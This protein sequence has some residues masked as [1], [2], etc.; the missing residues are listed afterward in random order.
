MSL[1]KHF[2]MKIALIACVINLVGSSLAY[3][4]IN[5]YQGRG[6][7]AR[8]APTPENCGWCWEHP[9]EAEYNLYCHMYC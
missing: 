9:L 2:L 1:Q 4:Q 8:P 3:A 6:V 5:T 7:S